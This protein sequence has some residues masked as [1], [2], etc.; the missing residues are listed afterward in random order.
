MHVRS[1]ITSACIPREHRRFSADFRKL[2]LSYV[3][4]RCDYELVQ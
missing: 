2:K 3:N 4:K 1:E